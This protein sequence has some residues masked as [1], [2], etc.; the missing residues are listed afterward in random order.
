MIQQKYM[1]SI[2]TTDE[3]PSTAIISNLLPAVITPGIL[4]RAM[5]GTILKRKMYI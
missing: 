5:V 2:L 4:W 3:W 1:G